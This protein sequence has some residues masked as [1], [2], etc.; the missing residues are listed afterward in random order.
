MRLLVSSGSRFALTPDGRLWT[1]SPAYGYGFW[2]RYLDSFTEVQLLGRARRC[3]TPPSGWGLASGDGVTPKPMPYYEGPLAFARIL[4]LLSWKVKGAVSSADAIL[5]RLPC[6]IGELVRK[7]IPTGRAFGVEV[8]GDPYDA[9]AP[10]GIKHVMR[11][12]FRRCFVSALK[13][14]CDEACAIGYVTRYKLQERYPPNCRA[15]TA[16][17]SDID[18]DEIAIVQRANWRGKVRPGTTLLSIGSL[19]QPYK[20]MDVLI[21]AL[22]ICASAGADLQLRIVGDGR[23]RG[24]LERRAEK[25]GVGQRVSFVGHLSSPAAIRLELDTADIFV[26]PSR[27]EGLP[28]VLLEAMA[29]ALPCI[30]TAV[31]GVPEL[32]PPEDLVVPANA[33]ALALKILDVTSDPDRMLDMARRNLARVAEYRLECLR[34]LRA[35]LYTHL[36]RCTGAWLASAAPKSPQACG[37]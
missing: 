25:R 35:E 28:K 37:H 9:F 1:P 19:Q 2:A 26:L 3:A 13:A 34:P 29:R 12:V 21:D 7:S 27:A 4:P 31:G 15:F 11:P 17:Y 32:L 5:L 22:S 14:A 10:G 33:Q 18:L 30:A 23:C 24:A 16:S 36:R 20:G 8:I 6:P